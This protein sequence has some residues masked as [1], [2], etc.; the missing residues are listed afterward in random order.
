MQGRCRRGTVGP[1]STPRAKA[2]GAIFML[3]CFR[4]RNYL[5]ERWLVGRGVK[6]WVDPKFGLAN[7]YFMGIV[8]VSRSV[9]SV[10]SARA[11]TEA[12]LQTPYEMPGL[13]ERKIGCFVLL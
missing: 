12:K 4:F 9:Q 10:N 6:A 11:R 13:K 2:Y 8:S 7:C 1:T 3:R 5:S